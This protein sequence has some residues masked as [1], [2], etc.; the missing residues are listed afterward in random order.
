M[1]F[2]IKKLGKEQSFLNGVFPILLILLFFLP[3]ADGQTSDPLPS[4]NEGPA[5][6]A[7][8]DFVAKVTKPETPDF[9]PEEERIAV[10]DNDGTLWCEQAFYFQG[11][12]L[13]DRIK[14]MA[15]Q[16]P[17]WSTQEPYASVFPLS[18]E[19]EECVSANHFHRV[20]PRGCR[21]GGNR[22]KN[23]RWEENGI[24]R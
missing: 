19:I 10:F 6:K 13:F 21:R 24:S 23:D 14:A 18:E 7:I 8:V 12:F 2:E 15:P 22:A 3:C 20:R 16:H 4:W 1:L 5:K 9:V 11:L 17:E